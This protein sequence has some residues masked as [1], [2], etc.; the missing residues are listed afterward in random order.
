MDSNVVSE[1]MRKSADPAV[2]A[3]VRGQP[4]ED[5]FFSAVGEAELRYGA[6]VLPAGRRRNTLV[7]DIESMLRAAFAHRILPF[8]SDAAVAYAEIASARRAAGRPVPTADCQIAAIARSRG[9]AVA[10]R[11]V[12]DFVD[13]GID[14]YDP[15]THA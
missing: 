12:R 1:L 10:T 5:L 4:V 9:M 13:M 11:N 15:W 6:A 14:V 2:E 7:S 3:W 8:D